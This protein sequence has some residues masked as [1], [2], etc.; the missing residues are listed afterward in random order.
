M[1]Y[2]VPPSKKKFPALS[3]P[4]SPSLEVKPKLSLAPVLPQLS[5]EQAT[6]SL[7]DHTIRAASNHGL[8]PAN[9]SGHGDSA[10]RMKQLHKVIHGLD[11]NDETY[12]SSHDVKTPSS[13]STDS[14]KLPSPFDHAGG[15]STAVT[16]L[17]S[18]KAPGRPRSG[19]NVSDLGNVEMRTEDFEDLG[20]LG[21]GAAGEVRKVK[22][23]HTGQV[24]AKKVI[25][26][27]SV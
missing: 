5:A 2:S 12:D 4:S 15:N 19:S 26:V 27:I 16:S 1:T 23:L 20:R 8:Y 6:P 7:G 13:T 21:E 17:H 25:P 9:E 18:G 3:L 10:R 24:M 22:Y 14:S 11:I